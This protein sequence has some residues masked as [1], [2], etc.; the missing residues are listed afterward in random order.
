[1]RS[2]CC[3]PLLAS[4]LVV[5]V[6]HLSGVPSSFSFLGCLVSLP[7]CV[8][9]SPIPSLGIWEEGKWEW[10]QHRRVRG[11]PLQEQLFGESKATEHKQFGGIIP[12]MGGGLTVVSVLCLA[13]S[14][15]GR[16][17]THKQNRQR[18]PDNPGK[19]LFMCLLLFIGFFRSPN[20]TKRRVICC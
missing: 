12:G 17:K 1:M 20:S 18:I 5:L 11:V 6:A 15:V 7:M 10:V 8:S 13:H 3:V 4:H 9:F 14:L 16:R 2:S 19:M